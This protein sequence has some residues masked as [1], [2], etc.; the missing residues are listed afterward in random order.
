VST[1]LRSRKSSQTKEEMLSLLALLSLRSLFGWASVLASLN[2]LGEDVVIEGDVPP[3]KNFRD[4]PGGRMPTPE[5]LL[6]VLE[7][8]SGLSEDD[9]ETI[10]RD[11]LKGPQGPVKPEDDASLLTASVF[12]SQFFIL[13][14][15]LSLITF[16][17][18]N[19]CA[20]VFIRFIIN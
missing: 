15:L 9:K 1:A 19:I 7:S 5:E 13:F 4:F 20:R 17:F 2:K 8:M 10:R 16:I 14:F 12:T 3:V 6:R 11:I 18:G